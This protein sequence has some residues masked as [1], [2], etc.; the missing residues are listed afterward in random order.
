MAIRSLAF[1]VGILMMSAR[2]PLEIPVPE[3]SPEYSDSLSQQ[4]HSRRAFLAR[5]GTAASAYVVLRP[6]SCSHSPSPTSMESPRHDDDHPTAPAAHSEHHG[7]SAEKKAGLFK[8]QEAG[9]GKSQKLAAHCIDFSVDPPKF[10]LATLQDLEAAYGKEAVEKALAGG[11]VMI[12]CSDDRVAAPEGFVKYGLPG[13][14][15]LVSAERRPAFFKHLHE[16]H[17]GEIDAV[18]FHECCGACKGDLPLAKSVGEEAGRALGKKVITS[19]Y[20][21]GTDLKMT[22]DPKFHEGLGFVISAQSQFNT[23]AL[24]MERHM[25]IGADAF[26]DDAELNRQ[27]QALVGILMEHGWGPEDFAKNPLQFKV[28]GNA[29]TTRNSAEALFRRL[30][31]TWNMLREK[32]SGTFKVVAFDA[33]HRPRTAGN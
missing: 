8:E 23:G 9:Y 2:F 30:Q 24:G 3:I 21:A 31:P 19:G 32:L 26:E 22:G 25:H 16:Q 15:A 10:V 20:S 28:V 12:L 33:P 11:K 14:G 6:G 5:M 7:I 4:P 1:L 13:S 18:S 29:D 17:G 27:V